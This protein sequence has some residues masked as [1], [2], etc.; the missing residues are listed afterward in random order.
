MHVFDNEL[1]HR[2]KCPHVTIDLFAGGSGAA[3]A[4]AAA[5]TASKN[6]A[7]AAAAAA[8]A[9][10]CGAAAAAAAAAGN[11]AAAAAAAASGNSAAA[12]AAASAAGPNAAAA[13]AAATSSSGCGS[14]ENSAAAAAAAAAGANA[15]SAAAAVAVAAA[16]G[17]RTFPYAHRQSCIVCITWANMLTVCDVTYVPAEMHKWNV[18]QCQHCEHR[19]CQPCVDSSPSPVGPH[20]CC[21]HAYAVKVIA[22]DLENDA[23]LSLITNTVCAVSE[24]PAGTLLSTGL[25]VLL[26]SK[27]LMHQH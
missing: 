15:G 10:Q 14:G 9:G 23:C 8:S 12:A 2:F 21:M 25:C 19:Q 27:L 17:E 26:T 7:S 13:A 4:A 22:V 5:V 6:A 16:T 1:R 11:A 20:V 24:H 3:A 18:P